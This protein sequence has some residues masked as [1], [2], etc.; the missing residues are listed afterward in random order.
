MQWAFY[1]LV[2]FVIIAL[3]AYIVFLQVQIKQ[4][5]RLIESVINKILDND[6]NWNRD[7]MIALFKNIFQYEIPVYTKDKI[8]DDSILNF[9]FHND[10][11]VHVFVH[12]T[13]EESVANKIME[14]GFRFANSFYKTA[15]N[16]Y[17]DKIDFSYRHLLHKKFGKF[18]VVICISKQIYSFYINELKKFSVKNLLLEQILTEVPP[19]KDDTHN[20]IYLL[21]MFYIKGFFNYETGNI[22]LN[23]DHNP[24][25]DSDQYKKNIELH[26]INST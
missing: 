21:P 2:F 18:V 10:K 8:M 25:Y 13:N 4:K 3:I 5:N 16:V 14:E 23:R 11:E 9:I 7:D 17:Y 15:E 1:I 20:D 19:Q 22:F 26:A 24:E 12:Y 6:R